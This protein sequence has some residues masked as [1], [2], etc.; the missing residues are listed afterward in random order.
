MHH[1]RRVLVADAC[2]DFA[3]TLRLLLRWWGHNVGIAHDGPTAVRL[4]RAFR[5]DV[6]ITDI[7]LPRLDGF[8]VAE[9]V[10]AEACL[11]GVLLVAVTGFAQSKYR[12]RASEVGFDH[13]L[14]K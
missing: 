10:R 8:A 14:I 7:C 3:A 2:K 9:L 6:I 1:T 12:Q 11:D 4:A 13:Y 5:P